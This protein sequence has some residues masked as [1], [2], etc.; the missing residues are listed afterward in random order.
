MVLFIFTAQCQVQ[1]RIFWPWNWAK[2]SCLQPKKIQNRHSKLELRWIVR[3]QL[4]YY[5]VNRESCLEKNW[6]RY[7]GCNFF[8]R[9]TGKANVSRKCPAPWWENSIWT[10]LSVLTAVLRYVNLFTNCNQLSPVQ[11]SIVT[12]KLV[13]NW[14]HKERIYCVASLFIYY[15]NTK[16]CLPGWNR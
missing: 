3:F 10:A 16:E 11:W 15:A 5:G 1:S 6:I 4:N 12:R 13:L 7:Q 14:R 2:V 9:P 8:F